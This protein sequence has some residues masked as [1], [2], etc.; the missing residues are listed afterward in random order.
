MAQS[1][2]DAQGEFERDPAFYAQDVI[3]AVRDMAE[4]FPR[5]ELKA[6]LEAALNPLKF[7]VVYVG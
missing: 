3:C 6:A 2:P 4:R 5:D 7:E 1:A